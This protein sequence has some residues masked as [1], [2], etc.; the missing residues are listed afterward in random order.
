ML[1][2]TP[3]LHAA[4]N[5]VGACCAQRATDWTDMGARGHDAVYLAVQWYSWLYSGLAVAQ[6]VLTET[7]GA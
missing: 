6:P 1:H 2:S 7:P 4:L 5:P 3:L